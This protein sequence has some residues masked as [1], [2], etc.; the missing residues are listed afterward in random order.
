[1]FILFLNYEYE[2]KVKK[3]ILI[4]IMVLLV[5]QSHNYAFMQLHR[6]LFYLEMDMQDVSDVIPENFELLHVIYG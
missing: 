2:R 4:L 3:K 6:K 5:S 1:M